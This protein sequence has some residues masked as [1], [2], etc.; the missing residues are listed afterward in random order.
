MTST[1]GSSISHII[2]TRV[3]RDYQ[4]GDIYSEGSLSGV[5]VSTARSGETVG[6]ALS[7]IIVFRKENAQTQF[8][9][10][11]PVYGDDNQPLVS[12]EVDRP[13]IGFSTKF[14]E[15][16][17]D[18]VEV[19]LEQSA[20]G[21]GGSGGGGS[22]A[23]RWGQ[24]TGKPPFAPANAEENVQADWSQTNSSDDSF[25]RN[26][27]SLA[28][29]NAEENV[30]SDWSESNSGSDA[31]IKNK[32]AI[33]PNLPS[34][35][36]ATVNFLGSRAGRL[37]WEMINE[38]P[39]SGSVGSVLTRTGS[40]D[41]DY[42]FRLPTGGGGSG[43]GLDRSAVLNL[44]ANW[45]EEGNTDNLPTS[46]IGLEP[47]S[48]LVRSSNGNLSTS[49]S[50]VSIGNQSETNRS[51][52][53][54]NTNEITDLKTTD[55]TILGMV[56]NLS[57]IVTQPDPVIHPFYFVDQAISAGTRDYTISFA[58]T[59]LNPRPARIN[60]NFGGTTKAITPVADRE[61]YLISL[62]VT[63]VRN[64]SS[65]HSPNDT[66]GVRISILDSSN[67]ETYSKT[68]YIPV[69][70][71]PLGGGLTFRQVAN[72]AAYTAIATKEPNTLYYWS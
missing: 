70:A 14:S 20:P 47:G 56:R 69:V 57:V 43:S 67:Q 38:V 54:T 3:T 59:L 72:Q 21:S 65:N 9:I 60:I 50:L 19:I 55:Q 48:G 15:R 58:S 30:Q 13:F 39:I 28:P 45:A 6:V 1:A 71:H 62:N 25:I 11:D 68:F 33:P 12:E 27:P 10:G 34:Y 46:K 64:L 32:P 49:P 63:E 2:T 66:I 52:I 51:G 31:F 40:G 23:V 42:A 4:E 24:V 18:R 26:K 7:G 5:C 35:N 61:T 29:A 44:I 8:N 22:G 16:G 36:Q 53:E 17:D 41:Q 37:F